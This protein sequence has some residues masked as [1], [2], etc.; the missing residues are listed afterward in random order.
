[1]SAAVA[2][3]HQPAAGALRADLDRLQSWAL[4]LGGAATIGVLAAGLAWPRTV[5]LAYLVG[6]LFWVGIAV[7]CVSLIMLHHLTGGNWGL[8]IRRPLESGAA[9]LPLMALL[10]LP[11]WLSRGAIYPWVHPVG[12]MAEIVRPKAAYLNTAFWTIRALIYF[13]A[14]IGL[15]MLLARLS[16]AQDTATNSR[17]SDLAESISGPGLA[18]IFFTGTF[19]A[20]DWIMSLEPAWYSTIY[21][22]MV[23]VGWGLST[24][25]AMIVVARILSRRQP[26]D[27]LTTAGRLNDL[28]NLMLAF[29]MLWAYLS[30]SQYLI[31]WAGNLNEE[32]PWYIR[33]VRGGWGWVAGILIALHFFLPFFVLLSRDVKR[34]ATSLAV[35][36]GFILVMR[37]ADLSWMVIPAWGDLEHRGVAGLSLAL[38]PVAAAGIGGLW[39]WLFLHN[40]KNRPLIPLRDPH[41]L[42]ALLHSEE[43]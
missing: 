16:R 2:A 8:V 23:I 24:F 42:E 40:L 13:A 35:V 17:P 36:A 38:V 27:A 19:A 31:I 15:G 11:L 39:L 20:I 21:S 37:L 18:V 30:F 22:A 9:T 10:F 25:A 5:M 28:G 4:I 12:E 3:A 29:V 14:W 33:R 6:Y 1:M 32:I 26:I 41:I 7:G 43:H 34:R